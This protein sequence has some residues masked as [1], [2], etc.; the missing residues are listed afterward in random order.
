MTSMEFLLP[1]FAVFCLIL[2]GSN[3]SV[4]SEDYWHSKLPNTPIPDELQ[5]LIQPTET[6]SKFFFWDMG[7]NCG[8][9]LLQAMDDKKSKDGD[10]TFVEVDGSKKKQRYKIGYDDAGFEEADGSK[11]RQRY[12]I[13]YDDAEFEEAD[14][15]KKKQRYKIGYEN[16]GFEEADGS[17]KKQRYKI[18]YDDAEFEEADGS[19]KKQRYKIGYDGGFEE[20]DGSKKKQRYK[21]EYDDA[22]FEEADGSKKKQRYKI[23][24]NDAD[25]EEA[26]GSKKKQKYKIGYDDADFEEADGSKKKQK[27]KIGYDDADFE[28]A[29]GSKKKQR[30]KIG[31]DDADFEEAD[32][33]KKKQRYKIGYDDVEFEE[34]DGSKKK[35]RYKIG[36][37]AALK[38]GDSA[39]KNKKYNIAYNAAFEEG[40]DARS[41]RRYKIGLNKHA[42]PNSTVFFLQKDLQA[43]QK[44]KLHIT[45]SSN[46]AKF[47]PRQ[48]SE[49]IPFSSKN[50]Q[51]IL[52]KFSIKPDSKQ[53]KIIKQTIIDCESQGIKGEEKNCPTSLES[54]ID[55]SIPVVGKKL[56]IL[57]NEVARPTRIQE[58]T[59]MGV[60][61]IGENQ[62]VCHKQ[63][64]PYAVYYCHSVSA[65]K[66]YQAPLVG[67][68]GIKAKAVAICHSDT[69]DWNPK[70]LA[71]LMLNV[72]PGEGTVCHFISSDTVVWTSKK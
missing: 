26:D 68:D 38:E 33:S 54:L 46:K 23:G 9:S 3:A 50:L 14:G 45:K 69:S 31:Y 52:Q 40:G 30:Y 36:Y 63:K 7:F 57:Y 6:G 72:K 4:P 58:Y 51:A 25:F 16:A 42:L 48:D 49:A 55:F 10:A 64:Y 28:E 61:M 12:K 62:V 34:A 53:A 56:Q 70:H 59:I 67:A 13:G 22:D 21:I 41:K 2:V 44:M 20:A 5:K 11:K 17:K 8:Q 32:G 71:F 27:Y 43:G 24:Y 65:T 66:V 19:K 15:S 29:D 18:G 37:D 1:L 39:E 60:E 47:L 35:Q